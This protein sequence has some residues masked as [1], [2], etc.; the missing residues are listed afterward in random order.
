VD[1]LLNKNRPPVF[2]PGCAHERILHAT[3]KAFQNMGLAPHQIVMVSDIGCSGL[4][5]V[6]FNTNALHGIHGR[7]LTYAAGLKLAR[8]ELYVVATIG[9]GGLG[10]GGAHLLSACRR[11]LDITL[12]IL[13]NFNFGMTGGQFSATTPAES[14]VGSAFLNAL[15]KPMDP[16]EIAVA[17]GAPFV[18]RAS[19]YQK[20]LPEMIEQAIRFEGFSVL[21]IRGICSGRYLKQNKLTPKMIEDELARL[22]PLKGPVQRNLRPEYGR[23]YRERAKSLTPVS[24]PE[25]IEAK[26]SAPQ[27]ARQEVIILGSAGQRIQTAGEI[28]GMAGLL[29]GLH[30]TQKNEYNVTVM[31][32]LSISELILSRE[33]IDYT[34]TVQPTV[35]IALAAE[36]VARRKEIFSRLDPE[37]LVIQAADVE[38]PPTQ[39]KIVPV[40][41][42]EQGIK[43]PDRA[44]ASLAV[45]AGMK[46][47]ISWE[48]LDAA[49]SEKFSGSV[50][51]EIRNQQKGLDISS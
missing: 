41:F 16:G 11:N 37:C 22:E 3:D 19:A 42:K 51:A 24:M 35:V 27:Q 1:S 38:I 20:D 25:G 2:C 39:A 45:L 36:G 8:P 44:T 47:V 12:L 7:V 26:F 40:N 32:G 14:A 48:M 6:F 9:D 50:L 10:I 31:V 23:S 17:A 43:N 30:V 21:D 34:G 15:E 28:L 49:L 4:F 33:P 13:N 46:R 5:D 29:A 18:S